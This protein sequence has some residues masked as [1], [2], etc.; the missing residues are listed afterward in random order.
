ME[1]EAVNILELDPP[2]NLFVGIRSRSALWRYG[3]LLFLFGC[4][5]INKK[6]VDIN[7]IRLYINKTLRAQLKRAIQKS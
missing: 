1:Q 3:R 6:V 2:L 4:S 7:H 5:K